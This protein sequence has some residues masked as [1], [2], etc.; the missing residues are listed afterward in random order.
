MCQP[1]QAVTKDNR[2]DEKM[3]A[4]L[5]HNRRQLATV[6]ARTRF[7]QM[8]VCVYR[9]WM[10]PESSSHITLSDEFSVLWDGTVLVVLLQICVSKLTK[11]FRRLI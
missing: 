11:H 7:R 9:S 10:R 5:P 8:V 2:D 3:P 4:V 6:G 1:Q